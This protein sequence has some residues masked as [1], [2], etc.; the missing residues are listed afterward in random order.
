MTLMAVMRY[1]EET[2]QRIGSAKHRAN[3]TQVLLFAAGPGTSA[4]FAGSQ[5]RH[6]HRR[7][8]VEQTQAPRWNGRRE[9][10]G[11]HA[12]LDVTVP[13]SGLRLSQVAIL[14]VLLRRKLVLTC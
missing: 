14:H 6:P 1:V 2:C 10:A 9:I 12:Y 3:Y 13:S 5:P 8:I 11:S 4:L 7:S